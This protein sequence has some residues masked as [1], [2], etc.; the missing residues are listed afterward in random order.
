MS[1]F[2]T[3]AEVTLR[4]LLGRRRT[5][6]LILLAGLPVLV[7]LLA[8]LGGGRLDDALVAI[9]ELGVRTV[10]P[11]TALV[12]GTSALGAELEDGTAVFI[13]AKPVPRWRIAL[14]KTLV[15]GLL[16]AALSVG[17]TLLTGLLIGGVDG[18]TLA[19]TFAFAIAVAL[20]GFAYASLFV[21]LSIVTGR[22]LIVGLI[23]TLVWEGILAGILEGTRLFS[24]REA[25]LSVA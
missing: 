20:A 10:L 17:S 18:S 15:A 5:V 23:Y 22:A 11:L 14:A 6:L 8:R 7:A 9:L 16:A 3:I 1:A 21:A 25:T 24:V 19:T 2:A 13:L 12:F 4:G